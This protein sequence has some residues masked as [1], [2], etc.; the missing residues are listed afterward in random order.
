[1]MPLTSGST[2]QRSLPLVAERLVPSP[3]KTMQPEEFSQLLQASIE[4]KWIRPPAT[5]H[6]ILS[7]ERRLR[8]RL[9]D[10]I[11]NFYSRVGG[12]DE[13]TP[14]EQGWVTFWPF[15]RWERATSVAGG[16]GADL[17]LVADHCLSSWWYAIPSSGGAS[18][19]VLIVDGLRPPRVVAST[20]SAFAE[21]IF[22]DDASIYPELTEGPG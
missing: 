1:M 13:A 12:C 11:R 17:V 2:I 7:V 20:F 10:D 9:P 8:M 14:V 6:D 21:A 15:E 19:P 22:K 4:A 18:A 3:D 5:E 16:D